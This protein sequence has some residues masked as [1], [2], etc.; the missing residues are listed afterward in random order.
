M[1]LFGQRMWPFFYMCAPIM[2]PTHL[3][4]CQ[5]SQNDEL[6]LVTTHYTNRWCFVPQTGIVVVLCKI[7][8]NNSLLE[9]LKIPSSRCLPSSFHR[10]LNNATR[11][12]GTNLNKLV[13]DKKLGN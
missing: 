4:S 10:V 9:L 8:L 13:N 5:W 3:E 11:L 1:I 6:E 7:C 12:P 2:G